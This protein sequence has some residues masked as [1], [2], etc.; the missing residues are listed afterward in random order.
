M[1]S[2]LSLSEWLF[3][4]RQKEG[5]SHHHRRRSAPTHAFEKLDQTLYL[6]TILALA[7]RP[8][9]VIKV[10]HTTKAEFSN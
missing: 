4:A 3:Q 10:S 6:S 5:R 9:I 8:P 1:C 2:T 7:L